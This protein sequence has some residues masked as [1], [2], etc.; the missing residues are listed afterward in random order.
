MRVCVFSAP[1]RSDRVC[2]SHICGDGVVCWR[3]SFF[4]FAAVV[5]C[6][7]MGPLHEVTLY[8]PPPPPPMRTL[9]LSTTP[10]PLALLPGVLTCAYPLNAGV[11]F[12]LQHMVEPLLFYYT[13]SFRHFLLVVLCAILSFCRSVLIVAYTFSLQSVCFHLVP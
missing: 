5:S 10:L 2:L 4:C 7:A 9:F 13:L 11:H 12:L 1:L 3:R 8:L 6:L